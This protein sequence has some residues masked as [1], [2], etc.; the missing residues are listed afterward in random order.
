MISLK[1]LQWLVPGVII[2]C[3]VGI[4]KTVPAGLVAPFYENFVRMGFI[5][6]VTI[7]DPVVNININLINRVKISEPNPEIVKID[8]NFGFC[9]SSNDKIFGVHYDFFSIKIIEVISFNISDMFRRYD[10]SRRL[11][12]VHNCQQDVRPTITISANF[13]FFIMQVRPELTLGGIP[14]N[15]IGLEGQ[16]DSAQNA[17]ETQTTKPRSESSPPSRS[18]RGVSGLPLGAKIGISLV[19]AG[20]A[21]TAFWRALSVFGLLLINASDVR[22]SISYALVAGGLFLVSFWLWNVA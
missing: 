5:E 6:D 9:T 1:G 14:C 13:A 22:K 7:N 21:W 19:I 4:M 8:K 20:L 15:P 2:I 17:K 16:A 3:L 12:G 11:S 18:F 10:A